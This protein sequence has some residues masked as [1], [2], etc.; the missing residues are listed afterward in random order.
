M[1]TLVSTFTFLTTR[2]SPPTRQLHVKP[3]C[4]LRGWQPAWNAANKFNNTHMY[5]FTHCLPHF[6]HL[7]ALWDGSLYGHA[8]DK[9]TGNH[10]STHPSP[11]TPRPPT[12][13]QGAWPA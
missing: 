10:V 9:S 12:P 4:M 11:A 7:H 8:M 13:A 2:Q 6:A 5:S 1:D 3:I